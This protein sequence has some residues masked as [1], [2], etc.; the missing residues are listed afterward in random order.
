MIKTANVLDAKGLACPMPLVKTRKA[1]KELLPGQIIEVQATDKGSTSDLKAWAES[2]GHHYLGTV[3]HGVV[4]KH[5]V[6]KASNEEEKAEIKFP[7]TI[8]NKDLEKKLAANENIVIVDVR[9]YAEYVF[10]HIPQAIS[11][12][13]GELK[14]RLQEISKKAEVY[15][16]CRTGNRSDLAAQ[17][18]V[19]NGYKNVVNVIP[20]MSEWTAPT[21]SLSL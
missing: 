1:M 16:I 14:N 8:S 18:L 11:I 3:E 17:I 10:Q 9:E 20:G 4:L 19:E 6:R 5:Y 21:N 12:P 15:V 7:H 2:V 13:L